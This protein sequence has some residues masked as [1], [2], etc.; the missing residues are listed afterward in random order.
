MFIFD[1]FIYMFVFSV[2]VGATDI[3]NYGVSVRLDTLPSESE[4]FL[5]GIFGSLFGNTANTQEKQKDA[6]SKITR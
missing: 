2:K 5:G 6:W 1:Y 3:S 4:G